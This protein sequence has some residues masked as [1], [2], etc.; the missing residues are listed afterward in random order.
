M[1]T[2]MEMD[3]RMGICC[4]FSLNKNFIK[5]H[6]ELAVKLLKAHQE[7]VKFCYENPIEASKIFA[8]YYGVPEEVGLMTMYKKCVEEGRTLIWQ[9]DNDSFKHAYDVYERYNLIEE[10]PEFED[11]IAYDIYEKAELD[12]F[13]KFIEE[14]VEKDFPLGMSYEEYKAKAEEIA[15][16]K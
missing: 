11:I 9:I 14:K 16:A 7:S 12:D 13:E 5:E 2:Y 15:K 6:P 1:E 8:E 10:L 4:A 3:E